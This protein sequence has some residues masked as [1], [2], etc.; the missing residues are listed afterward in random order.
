MSERHPTIREGHGS[1]QKGAIGP[2]ALHVE[3]IADLIC[4]FCYLGKR[5][6]GQALCAVQGPQDVRWL[7]WQ[8]NP[9]MPA[10]GLGFEDYLTSRFGSPADIEP[11]LEGLTLEGRR[12][13]IEFRFDR[14][15]HVPNTLRAH[16]LMYLAET[17]G[18]DQSALAEDLMEA[19]FRHGR[20]IG[21]SSV[22]VDIAGRH[23]LGGDQVT[24]VL[25]DDT[26]RQIVQT[27][28]AQVRSSGISGVPGFLLNR[29]LLLIGA[30]DADAIVNGFDRAMFG[31]GTD[32][33]VSPALH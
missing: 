32:E 26:A 27:R 13:G 22:L 12:E 16:Q 23:G 1:A 19:F 8:L 5:R 2:A 14:L 3:V 7:P 11:V 9:D 20:D 33:I 24:S 28:E 15:T 6:L 30:Q 10:A 31:E 25:S 18:R 4:P 29:R 21:D 17:E